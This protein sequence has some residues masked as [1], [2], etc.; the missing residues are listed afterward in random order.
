MSS[1]TVNINDRIR[2]INHQG[3]R[4][5]VVDFSNC[6]ADELEGT[7]R[8]VPDYVTS[9]PLGSV[10]ILTNF[11]GALFDRDAIRAV[12]ET[13]VFDKPF[14]KKSAL[15]GIEDLPVSF[16][17]DLKKYSRRDLLSFATREEALDWLVNQA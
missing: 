3:L 17:D 11:T 1:L 4:I 15:I 6:P 13:A 9:E 7:A 16:L 14:V 12:K 5:L 10:L 8:R 2:F